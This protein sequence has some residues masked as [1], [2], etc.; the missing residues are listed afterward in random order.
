MPNKDLASLLSDCWDHLEWTTY[1]HGR[2]GWA[3]RIIMGDLLANIEEWTGG[4][5]SGL[6][7]LNS[8]SRFVVGTPNMRMPVLQKIVGAFNACPFALEYLLAFVPPPFVP[9]VE[10]HV[11]G[12]P[13]KDEGWTAAQAMVQS[14]LDGSFYAPLG[15][16][17]LSSARE[18]ALQALDGAPVEG[19]EA[20]Q[21]LSE[22]L[23][24]FFDWHGYVLCGSTDIN[25]ATYSECPMVLV[26]ILQDVMRRYCD[27]RK[28]GR[29]PAAAE[30]LEKS[31]L[32]LLAGDPEL[33]K[34][35]SEIDTEEHR[36]QF[37]DQFWEAL[38]C[39]VL[40]N[41]RVIYTDAWASGILRRVM[42]E[43]GERLVAKGF[44]RH[45]GHIFE[46]PREEAGEGLVQEEAASGEQRRKGERYE[47]MVNYKM[48]AGFAGVP[49]RLGAPPPTEPPRGGGGG[50]EQNKRLVRAIKTYR[51]CVGHSSDEGGGGKPGA[52]PLP[53]DLKLKVEQGHAIQAIAASKGTAEGLARYIDNP[54]HIPLLRP[55]EVAV[56]TQAS[57]AFS[58]VLACCSAVVTEQGGILCHIAICARELHLPA[59]VGCG[60]GGGG[61]GKGGGG[62]GGGRGGHKLAPR[63]LD[64]MRVRVHGHLGIVEVLPKIGK[65]IFGVLGGTGRV[66]SAFIK[67][68]L[69]EGHEVRALV[70][71][72]RR[73]E[74]EA[75]L[76]SH[77]LLTLL[78][79]D[80]MDPSEIGKIIPGCDALLNNIG[81]RSIP[82]ATTEVSESTWACLEAIKAA[83]EGGERE[84]EG[85]GGGG[86][87]EGPKLVVQGGILLLDRPGTG[88][89]WCE[90]GEGTFPEF[91]K[92]VV[93]DMCRT[94]KLLENS[95]AEFL[96]LCCG[97]F[98]EGPGRGEVAS[99]VGETMYG[100]RWRSRVWVGDLARFMLGQVG[101]GEGEFLGRR[102]VGVESTDAMSL[103]MEES[104][105]FKA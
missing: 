55:G 4:S 39:S 67:L 97:R 68:A 93:A 16:P 96:M 64:G 25:S 89:M 3:H 103:E 105:G 73:E 46:V 40:K 54:A 81:P 77:R 2:Y 104:A 50:G 41:E 52:K 83:R 28:T 86:R 94:K 17:S 102:L 98:L 22:V 8:V 5:V 72:G 13:A 57:P 49:K 36:E 24:M 37:R 23:Q 26:S 88:H 70:R 65:R 18:A 99:F 91:F 31:S 78:V 74:A 85:Q 47:A 27:D 84:G 62:G 71:P 43:V 59:V 63:Q 30:M 60:A 20:R 51:K 100:D 66:G 80:P 53:S 58:G 14:L 1:L 38:Q 92:N 7:I 21:V 9:S 15:D 12:S 32:D 44:L 75:L 33:G 79:G 29:R 19:E 76:G 34:I 61:G 35:C 101:G 10:L 42:L 69:E 56:I 45:R 48:V 95:D 11:D 90:E 6:D 82:E 87:G